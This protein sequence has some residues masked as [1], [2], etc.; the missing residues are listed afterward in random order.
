MKVVWGKVMLSQASVCPQGGM[1]P[2][3][4]KSGGM[5]LG[6][7][8]AVL[9]ASEESDHPP[10]ERSVRPP[11]RKKGQEDH[12]PPRHTGTRS[13]RGRYASY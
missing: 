13:M 7:G 9:P 2:G 4:P 1:P 5:P 8:G 3:L 10:E 12:P 11:S 6:G